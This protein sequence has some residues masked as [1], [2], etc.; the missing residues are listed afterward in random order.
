MRGR[1]ALPEVREVGRPFRRFERGRDA[2]T[3][4]WEGSGG[5]PRGLGGVEMSSQRFG[6]GQE[7]LP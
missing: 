1:E 4:V 7:A 3:E 6:R 2:L 5:S